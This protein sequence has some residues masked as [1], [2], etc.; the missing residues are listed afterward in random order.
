MIEFSPEHLRAAGS[1]PEDFWSIL[2]ELGFE[3]WAFG[4]GGKAFRIEDRT[5]FAQR[6]E[7]GYTDI[8]AR[9]P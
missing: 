4:D 6:Y 3:P 7:T 8:W 5:A 2:D 9:R 1:G